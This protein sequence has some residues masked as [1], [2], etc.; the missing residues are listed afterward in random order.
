[1]ET[2]KENII[3][4]IDDVS[5]TFSFVGYID[6]FKFGGIEGYMNWS[7]KYHPRYFFET[8]KPMNP[9][10][11]TFDV[12]VPLESKNKDYLCAI[13][14]KDVDKWKETIPYEIA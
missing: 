3:I 6:I 12:Y 5:L 2:H 13:P 10:D 4:D 9:T 7:E 1:M 11:T 8:W 14:D